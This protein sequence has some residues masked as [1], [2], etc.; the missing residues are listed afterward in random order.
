MSTVTRISLDRIMP[1][2]VSYPPA[3]KDYMKRLRAGERLRQSMSRS[4][5]RFIAFSTVCTG[6]R[7]MS[8]R[9]ERPS[10]RSSSWRS[11]EPAS[12]PPRPPHILRSRVQPHRKTK[13]RTGRLPAIRGE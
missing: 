9:G 1:W 2:R 11:H 6:L 5:A 3:V 7:R 10:E 8:G 12:P 13:T 4:S